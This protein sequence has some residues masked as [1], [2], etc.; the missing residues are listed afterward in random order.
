MLCDICGVREATFHKTERNLD[1]SPVASN[2][3]SMR[4]Y[5]TSC[6]EKTYQEVER[7]REYEQERQTP[8]TPAFN[9]PQW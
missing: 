4:H 9:L 2:V 8:D 1:A 6:F 5:C 3:A 7:P